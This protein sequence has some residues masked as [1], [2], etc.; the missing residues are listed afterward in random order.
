LRRPYS[1]ML[2]VSKFPVEQVIIEIES[3]ATVHSVR[4]QTETTNTGIT[5]GPR[6]GQWN[7][8][9]PAEIAYVERVMVSPISAR[10]RV[11]IHRAPFSGGPQLI[12]DTLRRVKFLGYTSA[13]T[14]SLTD[15]RADKSWIS[16]QL[17]ALGLE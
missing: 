12:N 4:E 13:G 1:R 9:K 7:P 17:T 3:G 10:D 5:W 8:N 16:Y 15:I 11:F 2:P 6:F 14:L